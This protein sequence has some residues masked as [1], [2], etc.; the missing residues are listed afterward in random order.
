MNIKYVTG[1]LFDVISNITDSNILVPHIVNDKGVFGAGFAAAV[2]R[3]YPIVRQR[4]LEW[5][6]HDILGNVQ[7]VSVTPNITF[8]NMGGQ[9]GTVSKQNPKPIKYFKLALAMSII[10]DIN[11]DFEIVAPRFGSG[12]AKGCWPFI[13]ELIDELWIGAGIP[14]TIVTPNNA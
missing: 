5:D 13:E 6:T 7:F 3:H 11:D 2:T 4:Y 12:L 8:A 10:E 14:V 1:D 9:H